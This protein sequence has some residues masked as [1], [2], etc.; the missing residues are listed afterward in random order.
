MANINLKLVAWLRCCV[1]GVLCC[2]F[3]TERLTKISKTNRIHWGAGIA[4]SVQRLATG[5]TVR[6]SSP[7]GGE[8][9]RTRPDRTLRPTQPPITKGTGSFL[10][11]K[12]PGHGVDHPPHQATRLKKE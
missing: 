10:G 1:V 11:V 9:F 6:R 12:R 8:I 5:W 2:Q 7:G 4:Q 3:C